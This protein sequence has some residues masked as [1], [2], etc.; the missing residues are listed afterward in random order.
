MKPVL[1]RITA[2]DITP[3]ESLH[4]RNL[5]WFDDNLII[6]CLYNNS[7][8]MGK[9]V[10]KHLEEIKLEAKQKGF[11]FFWTE[12]PNMEEYM[13][14]PVVND[15]EYPVQ[16]QIE[17]YLFCDQ[18]CRRG[19]FRRVDDDHFIGWDYTDMVK[20]SVEITLPPALYEKLRPVEEYGLPEDL[21]QSNTS[22]GQEEEKATSAVYSPDPEND[23]HDQYFQQF[24]C[25][26]EVCGAVHFYK[27]AK[28]LD[29]Y[30]IQESEA[31][32]AR[33]KKR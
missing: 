17:H 5:S 33:C 11:R 12:D 7:N 27:I 9:Y 21:F 19:I 18:G 22:L 23:E 28:E 15:L 1:Y 13:D 29:F 8:W 3:S 10:A 30:D 24:S 2:K 31:S 4:K 14:I 32:C 6:C 16:S 25:Q 26:C 20:S